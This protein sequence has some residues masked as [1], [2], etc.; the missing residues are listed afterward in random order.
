MENP[1]L[2][3]C[4]LNAGIYSRLLTS[5]YSIPKGQTIY[6]PIL[7]INTDKD[8]W[9]PDAKEWKCVSVT[10]SKKPWTP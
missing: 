5:V 9:G 1:T 3:S 6:I 7:A 2:V 10:V 4:E 8:I